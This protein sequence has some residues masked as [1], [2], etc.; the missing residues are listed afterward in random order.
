MIV[1]QLSGGLG[2]QMFQYAAGYAITKKQN[3]HL[4]V[5][6]SNFKIKTTN[7]NFTLRDFELNIFEIEFDTVNPLLWKLYRKLSSL[8]SNLKFFPE[9]YLVRVYSE[10]SPEFDDFFLS[11]SDNA[12]LSGYFQSEKYFKK[13]RQELLKLFKFKYA[14]TGDNTE[15]IK[16][17]K[18][19]NSVSIHIRRG[20]YVSN[21]EIHSVHGSLTIKYYMKAIKLIREKLDN[22]HFYFF[23]DDI[24]WVEQN[25]NLDSQMIIAHNTGSES[26]RDMQLMSCCKHNIIANSS[27]SWWGAWLNENSEKIVISPL[28]WF[29]D[30]VRNSLTMDLIPVGWIR[31]SDV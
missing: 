3:S 22:P 10:K 17:I 26:Y 25:F 21:K 7:K 29:K 6:S 24:K 30:P 14:L 18:K 8:I 2:N 4:K 15:I 16:S 1:I 12:Y 23:S 27:F 20:D 28:K 31:L 11:I 13:Y 19:H 9:T 5:D